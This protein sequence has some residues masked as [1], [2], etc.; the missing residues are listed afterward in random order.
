[1][2]T[3]KPTITY[4]TT[5]VH[6]I[7]RFEVTTEIDDDQD[8]SYLDGRHDGVSASEI[9]HPDPEIRGDVRTDA[10]MRSRHGKHWGQIGVIVRSQPD[11]V[12]RASLWG[13]DVH[14]SEVY[15]HNAKARERAD[16]YF[17]ELLS[18]LLTEARDQVHDEHYPAGVGPN[19]E[20][21]V[22]HLPVVDP[23]NAPIDGASL[24]SAASTSID[25]WEC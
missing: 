19:D 20:R 5:T 24:R 25:W 2:M 4:E 1:M 12:V 15:R 7:E 9:N 13:I 23:N 16:A 3:D 6:T 18:G 8:I 22:D 10:I 11:N 14:D 21:I 17:G